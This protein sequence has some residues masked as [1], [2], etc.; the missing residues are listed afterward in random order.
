MDLLPRCMIQNGYKQKVYRL[1]KL[2]YV[3][4][5][6]LRAWFG[7]FTKSLITFGY[8]QSNSDLFL[9]KQKDKIITFI[10]YVD[11]MIVT[12][13]DPKERKALLNYLS[14]EFELKDIGHLKYFL[15]I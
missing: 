3:L 6:S 11:G 9:K 8:Q 7:R 14:K 10:I 15:E 12:R 1:K 13:N 4:K 5:Q 2:L